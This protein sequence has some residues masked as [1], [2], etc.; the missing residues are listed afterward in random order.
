MLDLEHIDD[1]GEFPK[2]SHCRVV[3][4][5]MVGLAAVTAV[6]AVAGGVWG[7]RQGVSS[8]QA[9]AVL[10]CAFVLLALSGII[11]LL[12][13]QMRA[14]STTGQSHVPIGLS[15][16]IVD[17]HHSGGDSD[18]QLI[19]ESI[20][21]LS[22]KLTE[23]VQLLKEIN[24]NTL[25][26][27]SGRAG[28]F[29]LL[30][31]QHRKAVFADVEQLVRQR[32]WAKAKYLLEGLA[33]RFPNNADVHKQMNGLDRLRR[34]AFSDDLNRA[35]KTI[36]E[37]IAISAWDRAAGNAEALLEKH[38]EMD[39]ARELVAYVS[40][41]RQRFRTE[42]LKRM[43]GDIQHSI[44]RK[45]WIDALRAAQQL[46]DRYPDSVDAEA[47]RNQLE[48]LQ[49]NAEIEK[50]QQLEVQIKDLVR[51]RSFVQALELARHVIVTYPTSPQADAL[52][53]QLEKFEKLAREHESDIGA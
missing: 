26:D 23:A 25:L 40:G 41:Q 20:T 5:V 31:E 44:S 43:S 19:G 50:R 37:F 3:F 6:G 1:R 15:Y 52:R 51:R 46:I 22:G 33:V 8:A 38:P 16:P 21:E 35:K 24:E 47:L 42:Q 39:A 9:V 48:T 2:H 36:D 18:N 4:W 32:E 7:F 53:E 11:L 10:G 14:R 27:E 49:T 13:I 30:A 45:R 17:E 28:K 34:A 29:E 12:S